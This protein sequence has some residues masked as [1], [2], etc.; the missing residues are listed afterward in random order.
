MTLPYETL[1]PMA[2]P[3]FTYALR[4]SPLLF[5]FLLSS[6]KIPFKT[7]FFL[8]ISCLYTTQSSPNIDLSLLLLSHTL[9]LLILS[10]S[11]ISTSFFYFLF[12]FTFEGLLLHPIASTLA[13]YPPTPCIQLF[14][15]KGGFSL[16]RV[17]EVSPFLG[18]LGSPYNIFP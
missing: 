17:R 7:Y 11:L 12:G 6:L 14:Y 16:T 4:S 18:D 3:T 13:E 15:L 8:S 2:S 9:G 1:C 10:I 5:I